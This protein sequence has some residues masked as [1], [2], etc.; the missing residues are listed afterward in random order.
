MRNIHNIEEGIA[1]LTEMCNSDCVVNTT[2]Y[3]QIAAWLDELKRLREIL[4]PLKHATFASY[5]EE[6]KKILGSGDIK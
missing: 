1:L 5:F 2:D 6:V 3:K 4:E